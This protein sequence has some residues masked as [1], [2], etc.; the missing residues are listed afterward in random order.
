M[1]K[2][3]SI[4]ALISDNG[5]IYKG[6]LDFYETKCILHS[7]TRLITE[8]FYDINSVEFITGLT[9]ISFLDL[10]AKEK[11]Y[12]QVKTQQ[13]VSSK[14]IIDEHKIN[15]TIS[16]LKN[17]VDK[18]TKTKKTTAASRA[19][20]IEIDEITEYNEKSLSFFLDNPYGILGIPTNTTTTDIQEVLEKIKRLS[21]F[22]NYISH[23]LKI[24]CL[25]KCTSV[26]K[27]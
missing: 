6:I 1:S 5:K 14:F 10:Y 23:Y 22:D 26:K 9:T 18:P 12:I 27:S 11:S 3:Y 7:D 16:A 8:F 19:V 4:K 17:S 25:L 13:E 24:K 2:I 20:P 21:R 15:E